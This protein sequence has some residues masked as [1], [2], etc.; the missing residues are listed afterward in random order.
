METAHEQTLK[1]IHG[2]PAPQSS[3]LID[4]EKAEVRP[5]IV[6]G[7]WFLVVTGNA[8]C[9]NMRVELVP[10]VYIQ[11]PDYWGIE[12]IASLPGP[13]CLP[14]IKPFTEILP[15]NGILGTKG[16]EVIGATKK[17]KIEVPS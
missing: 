14:Q 3:R 10:L 9:A 13:F 1:Q 6:N 4:F 16:I 15:L 17:Q 7:T 11:R 2:L 12:V 5:G 8:P